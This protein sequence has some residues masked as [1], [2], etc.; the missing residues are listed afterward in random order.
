MKR[1]LMMRHAEAKPAQGGEQDFERPLSQRGRAAALA[2]AR[3][4]AA[5]GLAIDRL[6]VSPARRTLE[7]GAIVAAELGAAVPVRHEAALYP[8]TPE[9]LWATL[10]QLPEHVRCALLI[11][12]NPALSALAHQCRA[13][14]PGADLPTAGFCLAGF[15][16]SVRWSA[17]K[18][19][20]GSALSL[21]G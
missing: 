9:S 4:I 8:G 3:Q 6:L 12:H 20:Q 16:A 17:L 2:A 11:G 18:Q 10:Q 5:S 14:D 7:T 13:A 21:P 19:E 15:P 1:V